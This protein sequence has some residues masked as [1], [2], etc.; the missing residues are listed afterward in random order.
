MNA[1]SA[2]AVALAQVLL[3]HHRR[4]CRRAGGPPANV[5]Q[6]LLPYGELCQRAALPYLTRTV[7]YFLQQVAQWCHDNGWPPINSL[8][9]NHESRMPGEG[10]EGAPGC[11]LLRWPVDVEVCIAF[12]AYPEVVA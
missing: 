3:D 9:V 8:A 7:G 10:Y 1:M 11:S 6:C 12:D 2:E 4:V 5:D